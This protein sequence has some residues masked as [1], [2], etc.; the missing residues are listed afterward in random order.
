M[1]TK[2]E[3]LKM[4]KEELNAYK[5][6]KEIESSFVANSNCSDCFEC[7]ECSK[8]PECSDCSDCSYCSECSY[9]FN[10]SECFNCSKCSYCFGCRETRNLKYAI[11]N[12]VVG[13]EAYKKKMEELNL[14]QNKNT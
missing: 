4:S 12:I 6:S 3:L 5:W 13:E 11:C 7:P 1:K 9:C 14:K 8:C 10:C 2:D